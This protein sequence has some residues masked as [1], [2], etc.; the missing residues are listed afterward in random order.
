MN[1]QDSCLS[2]EALRKEANNGGIGSEN[3]SPRLIVNPDFVEQL[4]ES[5]GSTQWNKEDEERIMNEI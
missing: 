4:D 3:D 5:D 1:A 2:Y